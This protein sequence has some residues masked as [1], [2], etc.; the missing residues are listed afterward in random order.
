MERRKERV[1]FLVAIVVIWVCVPVYGYD[2]WRGEISATVNLRQSPGLEGKVIT[3]L[4]RGEDVLVTDSRDGWCKVAIETDTYGYNGWVYGQYVREVVNVAPKRTEKRSISLPI[5]KVTLVGANHS[6]AAES[7]EE[8]V[9]Q[10]GASALRAP[11]HSADPTVESVPAG[12][13]QPAASIPHESDNLEKVTGTTP[14]AAL[15]P[16]RH[17]GADSSQ[18]LSSETNPGIEPPEGIP[19]QQAVHYEPPTPVRQSPES[20]I[21]PM[22]HTD[23]GLRPGRNPLPTM[24]RVGASRGIEMLAAPEPL[25]KSSLPR[26]HAAERL[27]S[28]VGM[29]TV[30]RLIL[31]MCM[32]LFCCVSLVLSYK[33]FRTA[34]MSMAGLQDDY[35]PPPRMG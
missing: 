3:L 1:L 20:T 5:R 29:Q 9:P 33:A 11:A 15:Q 35:E 2:R 18:A 27:V 22:A 7:P 24:E 31:R 28:G 23:N 34:R 17:A 8:I 10:R 19:P 25:E 6:P 13:A 14:S 26:V 16:P 12:A 4:E 32:V 30:V 21:S